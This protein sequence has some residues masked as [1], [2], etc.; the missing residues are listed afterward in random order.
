MCSFNDLTLPS[1]SP[2]SMR[3]IR[4]LLRR[5]SFYQHSPGS[6]INFTIPHYI[7]FY[8]MSSIPEEQTEVIL[9]ALINLL[10]SSVTEFIIEFEAFRSIFIQFLSFLRKKKIFLW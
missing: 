5:F 3:D 10:K 9:S 4:K 7:M 2:W 1:L 8:I 6:F